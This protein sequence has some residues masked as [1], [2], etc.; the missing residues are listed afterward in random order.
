MFFLHLADPDTG[1][2]LA[3]ADG[4]PRGFTYPTGM[5]APG[6]V[7]SDEVYLSTEDVPAGR[8]DLVIGWYDPETR[9]R[10]QAVDRQGMPLPEGRLRLPDTIYLP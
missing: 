10:L 5:W 9:L 1:R 7:I 3:Q 4:M 8:Y 2:P 6:E